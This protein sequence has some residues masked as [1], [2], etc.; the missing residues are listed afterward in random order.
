MNS[1]IPNSG[2][3]G[4]V[5]PPEILKP[6]GRAN[7]PS[8]PFPKRK[9]LPHEFPSWVQQ[10]ARHFI[11]INCADRNTTNLLRNDI[12]DHLLES[13]RFYDETGKWHLWLML[14]MPD[15][16]HFIATFNL[17]QGLRPILGAWKRYQAT[18]LGI[19]WQ[20]DF[21]EH[22]L[23]NPS[24]SDEKAFYI[25]MNPVRKNLVATPEQWPYILDRI[26]IDSGSPGGLALPKTTNLTGRA[27]SPSEP[28]DNNNGSAGGAALPK[29]SQS[30]E[31]TK[32]PAE[33]E[34]EGK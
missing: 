19:E 5:A 3:V 27:N 30:T 31:K 18:T 14:I 4:D 6:K 21:F 9:K 2:S 15:H 25:R 12:A 11:T 8:E 26:L 7:S 33:P 23:R 29:K 22:R 32:C 10:G 1:P 17:Q 13:A 20:S 28:A 16:I 24:E 34:S